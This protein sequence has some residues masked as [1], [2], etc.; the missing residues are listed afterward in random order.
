LKVTALHGGFYRVIA[1]YGFMEQPD[2]PR[3]V[4]EVGART[5]MEI[6][7]AATTYYLGRE[8]VL[9]SDAGAMGRFAESLFAYLQ[10]NAV[11]ADRQFNI[12]PHFVIE[13]GIQ[14]DL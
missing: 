6:D 5:A 12:P 10:R 13:I 8:S 3:L 11:A 9:A 1:R 7:P 14:V 2:V 4:Q